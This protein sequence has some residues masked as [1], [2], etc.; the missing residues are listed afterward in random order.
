MRAACVLLTGD[1]M[2]HGLATIARPG[3]CSAMRALRG[4]VAIEW[5]RPQELRTR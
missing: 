5:S 3:K 1:G 2:L 4:C